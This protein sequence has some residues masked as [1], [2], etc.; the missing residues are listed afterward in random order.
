M[1]QIFLNSTNTLYLNSIRSRLA[2]NV[3][4]KIQKH[5]P[6]STDIKDSSNSWRIHSET[7]KR[8]RLCRWADDFLF[9]RTVCLTSEQAFEQA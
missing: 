9:L 2:L 5:K 4:F 6:A 8:E 3:Q 7:V 1:V